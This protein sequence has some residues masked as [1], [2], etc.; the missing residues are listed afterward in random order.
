MYCSMV[1][2]IPSA[3][4]SSGYSWS[5][6]RLKSGDLNSS[7]LRVLK[8]LL[9]DQNSRSDDRYVVSTRSGYVVLISLNEYAVFDRKLDTLYPVEVDTPY[10]AI[11]QNNIGI[12]SQDTVMSDSK[13]SMVTYT[14][15]SSP[16]GGLSDI[17]PPSPDY[18]PGP[19]EPQSPP[20]PDFVP[21]PVYS[22][23][24]PP[25]DE[26]LPAKDQQ[27]PAAD[28]P[29]TDSPGYIPESDPEE[30]DDKDPEEDPT[31]YPADGGDDGDDEDEP[32]D[33]DEDKEA[34]SA[35]ETEPFETDE[36]AATPPPHPAY[37]VTAR[38]SIKDETP[39]SLP[40]RED[41]ERLLA[42]PTPPSSPLSPWSSPLPQIP[43]PPL[44]SIPSPS[45]PVSPPLPVSSP[46][47]VLSLS[48]PASPIRIA[49]GLA[50]EVGESSSAAAAR[51]AGGLRADYG[52]VA[53][54]DREIRRDPER[55][56]GYGIT[57]SQD[58]DELYTRLDDEQS[59]RQL[60]AG[61][62]N[63][64]FRDRRAQARTARLMETEARIDYRDAGGRS[65]EAEATHRGTE[66]DKETSDSDGRVRETKM[67]P[68]RATR[69]NIAPET[70]NTTSVTNA[71]LH[72]MINQGVTAALAVRDANTNSVDSHNSGTGVR[73]NE[74]A[75]RDSTYPD[76]MKCQPLNFKG[77]EGV[78][79]LTQWIEKM[80]TTELKKKITDKYCLRTEIK[81]LE[82][83]LWE[84]KVKGT[85]VI[86][87]NQRFQ[88]LAL[89]CGRMFPEESDKIEKYIGGLPDMIHES[90]VASNPKTMQEATE[91]T[92]E[93]MDKRIRTFTDRQAENKRKPD[94]NQQHHQNKRQ[95][96]GRAYAAGTVEKKPYGGSKAL[97]AKCNYHH[98]GPCAPKCHKCNKVGILPVTLGVRWRWQCSTKVYAVGHAGTNPDS[99]V[100]TGTFLLNNRYAS[101]LFDTGFD[102]SFV[103]TAFSSLIDITPTALDHYYDVE[104]ADERIIRLNTILRGCT[105][106][107][108]NHPF[109]IN[110]MPV[111][112]GSFDTIIGMDWLTEDKLEKKRLE[113]VPIVRDFPVVFPEDLSGLPPT[114]QVEFQ[115]DLIPYAAPV[116]RAPYRLAPSEMKELSE[117]LKELSDK[118]FIRPSSSPWGAPVLFVKKKDGSRYGHYEFKVMP[119]G[120]TNSPAVFMDLMN[121]VCKPYL[122]KFVI[123][124]IDDILIYSKNKQEHEEHLK[125]ILELL[126]KEELYAKFSKYE[127][128]IP[129][130]QFLGHMID[131][132]GIHVDPA[133]IKSIK[134]WAS[135]KSPTEIHQILGLASA[136]IPDL[137]EGSEDF[138]VYCDAS[139]KSL[140][141][142]FM[143]REKVIAYAS[144]QLKIHEKNYTTQDLEL[145]AVVFALKIWRHY[146]YGTK[147]TVFT[148]HKS[149]QHILDQKELN[150]RQ[151][152]WLELLSDYNC[153]IRYHSG[154][155]NVV[156]D[157][158]SRKEREPPLR[159]R[160]LVMTIGLNLPKQ[161]LDAH[162]EARKP[163]NIKNEDVGGMSVENSKDSEKLR[164]E[165][166]EPRAD[167]T[168]CLN[169]RSWLP[170]YADLRT[171]I[172]HE[173]H[174]SKYSIH[175][176]S[177]R[178]IKT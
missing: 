1:S 143:Q 115:I 81:K 128:W 157:A 66:A 169:G 125:L 57:D 170:C 10:S 69:S 117:Q 67:A 92:I 87:Y 151:R 28:S 77:T 16:F 130:V 78:V 141:V 71:Q 124:F 3:F 82:V 135:P 160:P 147:C 155:A 134:D 149:L 7:R 174:K 27:L 22:E 90:V 38:I 89:L 142:V 14:A 172:M 40:P 150:M 52:F 31:D 98:D 5:K 24:M 137:P 123:V 2:A 176:G 96:T 140:G 159:V 84:L 29:T 154:K 129:K 101:I 18:I 173:S 61:R 80:E 59:G 177:E 54:M 17:G 48:P 62:L 30:D 161:I 53:T 8:C 4:S 110:L 111:E 56:V 153:E 32:S 164:T 88:E 70:A 165:K 74:R 175:P 139:I 86:G 51:P 85:D 42:M 19:E 44:P 144:R 34:S 72:A 23:F 103:S 36:S 25:E 156:V 68:K 152:R 97:C 43:S 127:F 107:L 126:K 39:I 136:P 100:V 6:S 167:G 46:V 145:G 132:Q 55:D 75:T 45:L 102:R 104:L 60:L 119:F 9:D 108:P 58:T 26:I 50:Y 109:N 41:V 95:N 12:K 11:D 105:L 131:S 94:N 65:Q 91:M 49:L 47:P 166:L 64:L 116:A 120:L 35:E 21:E 148:D 168:L 13:D 178:C 133:K 83:E 112:L 113:D 76:F 37:C 114:R 73:R 171:L 163:E 63:M 15:V 33:D 158:L 146:L 106:N 93:V 138:I 20:P 162:T 79:E 118:G 121:R 99:N 122:D